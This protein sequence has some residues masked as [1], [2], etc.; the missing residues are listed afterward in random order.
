ERPAGE[1]GP[2]GADDVEF[3]VTTNPGQPPGP[4]SRIASGGELSRLNLAIQVVATRRT[5]APTL[6]FDEVDAGVGGAVAE[7][8]GR[9]LRALSAGRQV[10]CI[11]HLP[12]VA[13]LAGQ[14]ASV[15][16]TTDSR[17]TLTTVRPLSA[18]ERIEEIA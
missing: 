15:S 7:I 8:V 5:G 2:D 17:R 16:K 13:A 9:Q 11:T 10:L 3:L 1:I 18:T 4:L 12:Q 6:I 14:Q